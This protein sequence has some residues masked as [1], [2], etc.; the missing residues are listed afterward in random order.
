M[1][2]HSRLLRLDRTGEKVYL[3]EL[4]CSYTS[5]RPAVNAAG[6]VFVLAH[7]DHDRTEVL[8]VSSDGTSVSI[9]VASTLDGGPVEDAEILTLSPGGRFSLLDY[10]CGWI[11]AKRIFQTAAGNGEE[12][13]SE[14]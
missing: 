7:R 2:S 4:P 5:G 9:A 11:D 8:S 10:N 6:E 12:S 13:Q 1:L 14:G 3:I